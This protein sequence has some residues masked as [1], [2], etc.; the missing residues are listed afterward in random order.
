M[1]GARAAQERTLY[2]QIP[3]LPLSLALTSD[4][5]G[6]YTDLHI[7]EPSPR[8]AGS[9]NGSARDSAHHVFWASTSSPSGGR[10]YLNDDGGSFDSPATGPTSTRTRPHRSG[11]S[12]WDA[13]YW[14]GQNHR[15]R[16]RHARGR[17]V[18]RHASRDPPPREASARHTRRDARRSATCASTA[19]RSRVGA[20]GGGP[21]PR[22][23]LRLARVGARPGL[24]SPRCTP[25][26]LLNEPGP[27]CSR[28]RW[29]SS[30]PPR[31]LPTRRDTSCATRRSRRPKHPPPRRLGSRPA[32]LRRVG[33]F[34]FRKALGTN[35]PLWQRHDGT[36]VSFLEAG[37]LLAYNF[38]AV[39]REPDPRRLRA[40]DLLAFLI[41]PGRPAG[42]AWHLMLLLEPPGTAP[43]RVLVVY[44]NGAAPPDGAVRKVWLAGGLS[45]GPPSGVPC[46]AT[47]S[48]SER[49]ATG[50]SPTERKRR[51][52]PR[53][54]SPHRGSSVL[55][56]SVPP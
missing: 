17:A 54:H 41:P 23:R 51:A 37:E 9:R 3:T 2:A 22:R 33:R 27:L 53:D 12:A 13:N 48:S 29:P 47:R 18:R 8:R 1:P 50:P 56:A 6:V 19:A 7:Y 24:S 21:A 42:D 46:P 45:R 20:G 52:P 39:S 36:R 25:P 30:R 49:S 35:E 44:H 5:D 14:A 11:S 28:S 34:L 55:P 4:T 16:R 26:E 31:D 43:D 15:A 10:F 38:E 40:G 32:R